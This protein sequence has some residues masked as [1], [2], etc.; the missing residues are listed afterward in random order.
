M[1]IF[2]GSSSQMLSPPVIIMPSR[3][4][5]MPAP[6]ALQ[7]VMCLLQLAWV[8]YWRTSG[9]AHHCREF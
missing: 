9:L 2:K 4:P 1:V 8:K 7:G 6:T 5:L 3:A